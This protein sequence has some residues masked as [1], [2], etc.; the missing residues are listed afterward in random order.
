MWAQILTLLTVS[1]Q[2]DFFSLSRYK[3]M[4][5]LSPIAHPEDA[6]SDPSGEAVV[7]GDNHRTG[8]GVEGAKL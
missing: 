2:Y 1:E 5:I 4:S 8:M 7:L 6:E 3:I